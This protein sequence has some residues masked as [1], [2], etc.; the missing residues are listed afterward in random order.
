[1]TQTPEDLIIRFIN[2]TCTD[3]EL[4]SLKKWLDE[5]DENYV[6]LFASERVALDAAS[7]SI[8]DASLNRAKSRLAGRI[9]AD[10][11]RVA[12][13]LRRR[14]LWRTVGVAAMLSVIVFAG[15]FFM[16]N[17][18][19]KMLH[20]AAADKCVSLV[21]PDS[22]RVFL[23]S[24]SRLSYP[25]AFASDCREVELVGEGYFEVSHDS[26]RPFRVAGQY[27]NV[28]VLGTHFNFLSRDS[29]VNSVSLIEGS[30]EVTT[31]DQEDGVVLEPGQKAVYSIE[32]GH[33]I[34]QNANT[35]ADASWH[36]RMIPF[37]NANLRDIV[38]I[39]IQLYGRDIELDRGVD[40]DKTYSGVTVYCRDLD[41][42]LHGLSNTIP[43][44][45]KTKGEKT[46][47]YAK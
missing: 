6:E 46:F 18:E 20:Y 41:S 8:D 15:L 19:T 34:V 36:N 45:F 32:T 39:L 5:S 35:A 23:N 25:E 22:T 30:V 17:S 28:E 27:L 16:R 38:D 12:R 21:L 26:S 7:L 47:I 31:A 44:R 24:N 1:M 4:V 29:T 42:T 33:L 43:I 10:K 9:S 14:L 37:E 3:E 40:L 11:E 13:R 2:N